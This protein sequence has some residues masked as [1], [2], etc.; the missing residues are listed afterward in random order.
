[1]WNGGNTPGC[2]IA[3]GIRTTDAVGT[4]AFPSFDWWGPTKYWQL[5]N[6]VLG[7]VWCCSG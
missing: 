6:V 4:R 5:V 2:Y 7:K 1:M 3:L